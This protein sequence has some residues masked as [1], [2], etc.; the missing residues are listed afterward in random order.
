MDAI[1]A[2]VCFAFVPQSDELISLNPT[3]ASLPLVPSMQY[4]RTFASGHAAV[5]GG[6]H[7]IVPSENDCIG[8]SDCD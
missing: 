8:Q 6:A 3:F 7:P 1:P 2:S 4:Q 5:M